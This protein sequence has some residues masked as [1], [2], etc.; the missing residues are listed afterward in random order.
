MLMGKYIVGKF[1]LNTGDIDNMLYYDDAVEYFN[2]LLKQITGREDCKFHAFYRNNYDN[3]LCYFGFSFEWG[4]FVDLEQIKKME[5]EY[6]YFL[7]ITK[8]LPIEKF[9][10]IWEK[11]L[12]SLNKD[13]NII[14]DC[15][16]QNA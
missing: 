4:D 9:Q 16:M 7:S 11:F 1:L 12:P 8:S 5:Q 10:D 2:N 13:Q 6:D 14:L 3:L 15:I